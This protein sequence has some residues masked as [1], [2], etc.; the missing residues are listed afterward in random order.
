[1]NARILSAVVVVVLVITGAVVLWSRSA[2]APSLSDPAGGVA[3]SQAAPEHVQVAGCRFERGQTFAFGYRSQTNSRINAIIPGARDV[4]SQTA[5]VDLNGTLNFEVL[6]ASPESTVLLGRLSGANDTATR[7]AG[8]SLEAGFLA[9]VDARCEVTA[10][11]RHQGTPQIA[12]RA[13]HV[14]ASDLSFSVGDGY[15]VTEVSFATSLGTLR[16]MVT[17]GEPGVFTRKALNYTS[18]WIPRMEGVNLVEGSLEARRGSSGW[19]ERLFGSEAVSGAEVQSSKTE[20]SAEARAVDPAALADVSRAEG[21]YVWVNALG[22]VD[23]ADVVVGTPSEDHDR[24]VAAARGVT[25]D[26]A[27]TRF[28]ALVASGANINEQWRDTAAWL[29]AHPDQIPDF[30]DVITD[31]SFP[32][33]AKAPAFLALG[34]T[35]NSVARESLL[36]IFR[37]PESQQ[38]DKIRSSLALSMRADVGLPLAKELKKVAMKKSADSSDAAVARQAVLHLG[39]LAGTHQN[40]TD[41]MQESLGLVQQLSTTAK[42]ADDYSVLFGLV[43]NMA[44]LSLLP[45][46]AT[47]SRSPDPLLRR[48]LPDA[49]RRYR[50]ERVH[51]LVLDWLARESDVDVKREL[52]ETLFHMY[53]DAGRPVEEDL[54]REALRHLAE[55]PL[56]L[57]RQSLYHLLTPFMDRPEVHEA[58]KAALKY[59]LDEKSGLYSLVAQGLPATTIYEVFATLPSLRGQYV[60]GLKPE[61]TQG[62]PMLDVRPI[63]EVPQP[64][65]EAAMKE[66]TP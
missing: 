10:F 63:N 54:M 58:F 8:S 46:I 24:R 2:S 22:L 9:R 6:S 64:G 33:G 50:V 19:V 39:V 7:A 55:R 38:A 59:E 52:F 42:T 17:R 23:E 13:Q 4:V 53:V 61:A 14:M 65:F 34:Q 26:A 16:T 49:I 40:Q 29:D 28:G 45:Q 57:T 62:V 48:E 56:V 15:P 30:V 66:V 44:E 11:A 1:M 3:R 36:G 47:W 12:A 27:M 21:D 37:E 43:G 41:V 51:D 60:G 18:H 31:E 5:V 35:Q 20:W 25:F 32:A